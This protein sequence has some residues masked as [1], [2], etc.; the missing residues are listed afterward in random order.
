MSG[1]KLK[2]LGQIMEPE[3]GNPMEVEGVLNPAAARGPDGK[4]YL[5]PRLVAKGNYSRIGVARVL[6]N[7]E[8]DPYGVERLGIALEPEADYE[9]RSDGSGGCEDA[10]ITYIEPLQRYMMTYTALSP[11]GPRIAVAESADLFNWKRLGLVTFEPYDGIDFVHVDNKDA[12]LFPVAIP[13]HAGKMQLAILHRPLFQRPVK[14][15]Q[16]HFPCMIRNSNRE[17][18]RILI[19]HMNEIYAIVWLSLIHI[20]EPTR[21]Y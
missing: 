16:L 10:R 15:S 2:R 9:L 11:K 18:A 21:P 7:D 14:N 12:S 3:P 20:S 13:N 6:F 19:I 8:G 1:I 17:E 4:L 5:F